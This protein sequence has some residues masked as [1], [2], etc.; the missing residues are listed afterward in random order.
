MISAHSPKIALYWLPRLMLATGARPNALAQLKTNALDMNFN[1]R[2]HLNVLCLIDDDEEAG[3][4]DTSTHVETDERR[5]KTVAG[6]RMVPLHPLLIKAGFT[7]FVA[8]RHRDGAKQ[9]FRE[10]TDHSLK[11]ASR[12]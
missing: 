8:D 2:P 11:R 9:L 4:P 6:R 1:G 5:V 7:D 10:R 12:R 3:A